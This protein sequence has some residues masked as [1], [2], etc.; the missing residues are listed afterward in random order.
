MLPGLVW[1]VGDE[2]FP[3]AALLCAAPD[4]HAVNEDTE[5]AEVVI[6]HLGAVANADCELH[7]QPVDLRGNSQVV[8]D[9]GAAIDWRML[10]QGRLLHHAATGRVDSHLHQ[11]RCTGGALAGTGEQLQ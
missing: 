2:A 1:Q 5:G 8:F 3:L 4:A 11:V 9:D 10:P 7:A 6:F